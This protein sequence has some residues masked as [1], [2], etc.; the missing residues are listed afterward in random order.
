M[1]W[2]SFS[3]HFDTMTCVISVEKKPDSLVRP[4]TDL[5]EAL[6]EADARMYRDKEDYY[7]EHPEM[8]RGTL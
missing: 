8:K 7:R 4:G 2:K 3:E 5:R 1:D 6:A